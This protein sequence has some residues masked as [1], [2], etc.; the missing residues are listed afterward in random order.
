[1]LRGTL[2]CRAPAGLVARARAW[3]AEHLLEPAREMTRRQLVVASAVGVWGG[4]FPIPPCTSPATLF[5]IGFFSAGVPRRLRFNVPMASIAIV[6]NELVLPLDLLLMPQFIL[7]G[8]WAD[9]ALGG[10]GAARVDGGAE[11]PGELPQGSLREGL[12]DGLPSGG[13]AELLEG[14]KEGCDDDDGRGVTAACSG[15]PS[16]CGRLPPRWCWARSGCSGPCLGAACGLLPDRR[17]RGPPRAAP[18]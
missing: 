1:M 5:C 11:A 4:V 2:A 9:R 13:L 3:G 10:D 16:S 12:L 18:G 14:L 8:M 6:L 15:G 17:L 7:A